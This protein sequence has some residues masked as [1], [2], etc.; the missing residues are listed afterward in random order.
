MQG[1][2]PRGRSRRCKRRTR[3]PYEAVVAKARQR[4]LIGRTNLKRPLLRSA[5]S[6]VDQDVVVRERT[7]EAI[8]RTAPVDTVKR[9]FVVRI[10]TGEGVDRTRLTNVGLEDARIVVAGEP[11]VRDTH[12][13]GGDEFEQLDAG[14]CVGELLSEDEVLLGEDDSGDDGHRYPDPRVMS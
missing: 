7:E 9:L 2:P 1:R 10:E 6:L 8:D 13:L 12:P 5:Y 4:V 14:S 11:E 3:P